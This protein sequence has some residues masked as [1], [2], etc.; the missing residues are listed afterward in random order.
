MSKSPVPAEANQHAGGARRQQIAQLKP[1]SYFIC[2]FVALYFA[3]WGLDRAFPYLTI[4]S[5]VILHAK[6]HDESRGLIFPRDTQV[7]KVAIFGNSRILAGLQAKHFDDL[8]RADG[9]HT[10]TY[11]GGLPAR[12]DFVP[13]LKT[14][15]ST[16]NPPDVVLLTEPWA[17]AR[18]QVFFS[19]PISDLELANIVFP[20]RTFLRDA[21]SFMVTSRERGGM[22]AFYRASSRNDA[23]MREDHG[24]YFISEQSHYAHDSLPDDFESAA[25][26]PG[27]VDMRNGDAKSEEL[28]ELND[29]VRQHHIVC[30]YVPNP[31]RLNFA[32][33]PPPVDLNF[34]KVLAA[35]TPC[36][37]IGPDYLRYPNRYFADQ[38]HLNHLGAQLY[39]E[40]LY[41]LVKAYLSGAKEK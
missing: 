38:T 23:R 37:L 28:T 24:Y 31:V 10:Y 32:A 3:L 1:I 18:T 33:Q 4:G 40:D 16:G 41:R 36:K 11:N 14:I 29:L 7:S 12:V 27:T 39:T 19:L 17:N 21:A 35:H 25:D 13:E 34:E 9:L 22:R 30:L 20:F 5:D 2:G 15:A 6:L 8:A 26:H